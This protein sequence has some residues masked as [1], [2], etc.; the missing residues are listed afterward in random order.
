MNLVKDNSQSTNAKYLVMSNAEI[1][2]LVRIN[3]YFSILVSF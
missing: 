3:K 1:N 2:Q